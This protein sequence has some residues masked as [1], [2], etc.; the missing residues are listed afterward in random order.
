MFI[1]DSI[2][3]LDTLEHPSPFKGNNIGVYGEWLEEFTD[4]RITEF[5]SLGVR[6]S[7]VIP[8]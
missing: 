7:E 4:R 8:L 1:A 6:F 3:Y 2:V 5:V